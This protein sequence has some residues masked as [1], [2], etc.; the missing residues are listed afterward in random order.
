VLKIDGQRDLVYNGSV[1]TID[2]VKRDAVVIL[3]T[4]VNRMAAVL[5]APFE[6][7]R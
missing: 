2:E 6:S 7:D 5:D 3:R 4:N 1:M